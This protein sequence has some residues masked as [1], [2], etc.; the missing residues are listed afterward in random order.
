MR[1]ARRFE[2]V[3]P[4]PMLSE[5]WEQ[6]AFRL[7]QALQPTVDVVRGLLHRDSAQAVSFEA[8]GNIGSA[9]TTI[10]QVT[11]PKGLLEINGDSIEFYAAGIFGGLEDS[12]KRIR[13]LF[14]SKVILDTR[15]FAFVDTWCAYGHVVRVG[16]ESQMAIAHFI[17]D[18]DIKYDENNLA[19][20][21]E[22]I[23]PKN[24]LL[25]YSEASEVLSNSVVLK[26]LGTGQASGDVVAKLWKVYH[27]R[28]T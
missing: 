26:V 4:E 12:H 25:Q 13:V 5:S 27:R 28:T 3:L 18:R 10:Q 17:A 1:Q 20:G 2:S 16:A 11:L 22:E 6:Y 14:G 7:V 21:E 19:I 24:V 15:E 8:S 23:Q 9:E